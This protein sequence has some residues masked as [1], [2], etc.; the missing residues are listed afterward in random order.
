MST[1]QEQVLSLD[2]VM[3]V[4]LGV[5]VLQNV[6]DLQSQVVGHLAA[7]QFLSGLKYFL[8]VIAEPVHDEEPVLLVIDDSRTAAA[9]HGHPKGG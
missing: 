2:V 1:Y 7:E 4:A 5:D 9:E 8:Q 6:E 3:N